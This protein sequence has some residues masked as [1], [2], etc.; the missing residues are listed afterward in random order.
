MTQ[1][2]KKP[3]PKKGDAN[4]MYLSKKT[5]ATFFTVSVCIRG[6]GC[7]ALVATMMGVDHADPSQAV[8]GSCFIPGAFQLARACLVTANR[9][10]SC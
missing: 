6:K 9:L 10:L 4:F 5:R 1:H 8:C 3:V 7:V 2:M